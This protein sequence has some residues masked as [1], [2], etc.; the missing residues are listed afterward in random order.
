MAR[1]AYYQHNTETPIEHLMNVRVQHSV[2]SLAQVV[3]DVE[4]GFAEN[5]DPH[6]TVVPRPFLLAH[7]LPVRHAQMCEHAVRNKRAKNNNQK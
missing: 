4:P 6:V 1:V 3:Q 5:P 7:V 2:P